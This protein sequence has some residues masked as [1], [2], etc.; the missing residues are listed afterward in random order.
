MG[1]TK[2]LQHKDGN[3]LNR[4]THRKATGTGRFD[5]GRKR[6]ISRSQGDWY[7]IRKFV[8]E[9]IISL[10]EVLADIERLGG[11]ICGEKS[12]FLKDGVKMVVIHLWFGRKNT[13]RSESEKN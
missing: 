11:T 8:M 2:I 7:S 6:C 9:L 12:E 13:R 10:D 3:S 1:Y 5:D 4:S